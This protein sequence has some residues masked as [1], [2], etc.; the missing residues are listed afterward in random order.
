MQDVYLPVC[1]FKWLYNRYPGIYITSVC[2]FLWVSVSIDN[3][4][5]VAFRGK[6]S[7]LLPRGQNVGKTD[8]LHTHKD[9]GGL[10]SCRQ[11]WWIILWMDTMPVLVCVCVYLLMRVSDRRKWLDVKVIVT[12]IIVWHHLLP[13]LYVVEW[14]SGINQHS[15]NR[16]QFV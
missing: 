5:G 12:H 13:S 1:R 8:Y 11:S 16:S 4:S 15:L 7:T 14:R 9:D 3:I 6:R 2:L 10:R